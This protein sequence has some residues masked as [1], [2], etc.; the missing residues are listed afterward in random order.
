MFTIRSRKCETAWGVG[1][2]FTLAKSCHR[3]FVFG[4]EGILHEG[5]PENGAEVAIVELLGE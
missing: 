4:G 1:Q 5:P 2:V 3:G